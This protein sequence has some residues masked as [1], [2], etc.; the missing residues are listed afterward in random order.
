M[1]P[2]ENSN[3]K[4]FCLIYISEEHVDILIGGAYHPWGIFDPRRS[5]S[6][7]N[8]SK[9]L[10][11]AEPNI[12]SKFLD[13]NTST[14]FAS[15]ILNL[16]DNIVFTWW[17]EILLLQFY[18]IYASIMRKLSRAEPSRNIS[19]AT[20]TTMKSSKMLSSA[21]NKNEQE[22]LSKHTNIHINITRTKTLNKI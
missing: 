4:R 19:Q 2:L 17:K 21:T 7:T 8:Q 5:G 13:Q 14:A 22:H 11:K 15:K 12:I 6:L 16:K 18:K 10:I 9:G 1:H 3:Q 20:S